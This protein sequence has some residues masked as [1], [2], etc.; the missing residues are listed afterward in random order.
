MRADLAEAA[1]EAAQLADLLLDL[2][3]ASVGDSLE[4]GTSVGVLG[5]CGKE[6][7][8]FLDTEP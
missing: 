7:R 2:S 3:D 1:F 6:A 5:P 8:G 4:V